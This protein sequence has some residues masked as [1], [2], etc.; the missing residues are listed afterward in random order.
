MLSRPADLLTLITDFLL[1]N[2]MS[3]TI[4]LVRHGENDWV[5]SN[6]LAGRTPGVQLNDTGLAQSRRMSG[7][8][9]RWPIDAVYSSPLERC[10]ETATI[11]ATP[12]RLS[13]LSEDGLLE[14]D[15]G[16]WQGQKIDDLVKQDLWRV[17]QATPGLAQFPGGESMLG[18]QNRMIGTLQNIVSAHPDQVVLVCSHADLIKAAVSHYTGAPFDLFQ[19]V[20]IAP[21]SL[22]IIQFSKYGP[23]VLRVND[24]GALPPPKIGNA[25]HADNDS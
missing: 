3:T 24:T 1:S 20:V 23:M 5:K 7:L 22:S 6:K 25:Q 4:L 9:A 16:E 21:C 18:M 11:L 8:L 12:H 13:V 14:T 17:I 19:R 15:Y 2:P 10:A